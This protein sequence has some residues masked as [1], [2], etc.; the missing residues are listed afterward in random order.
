MWFVVAVLC[1]TRAGATT[2][3]VDLDHDGIGDIVKISQAPAKPGL[4]LWLSSTRRVMRLR[5]KSELSTVVAADVD[6]DGWPDLVAGSAKPGSHGLHIWRNTGRGLFEQL[7][8]RH[9]SRHGR[10]STHPDGRVA[11]LPDAPTPAVKGG[12]FQDTG[13]PAELSYFA[14]HLT[15]TDCTIVVQ[16]MTAPPSH[17][18][19]R[20]PRAPPAPALV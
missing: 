9:G 7:K 14:F 4:E 20:S 19:P 3:R 16:C 8:R 17:A 6:A 15:P 2:L 11:D 5:A 13:S 18:T 12:T 1:A 10:L